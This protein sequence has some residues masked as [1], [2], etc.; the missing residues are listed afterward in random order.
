MKLF[1]TRKQRL[2]LVVAIPTAIYLVGL[3]AKRIGDSF[4]AEVIVEDTS[5]FLVFALGILFL[6]AL[7]VLGVALLLIYAALSELFSWIMGDS[8]EEGKDDSA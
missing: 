6:I 3:V 4:W 5:I 1:N 2:L 8:D 7:A